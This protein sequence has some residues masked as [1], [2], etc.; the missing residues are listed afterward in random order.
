MKLF[1]F[2]MRDGYFCVK[3]DTIIEKIYV[4]LYVLELKLVKLLLDVK[5]AL[6]I[7]FLGI[8]EFNYF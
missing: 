2:R 1:E 5:I 6:F 4:Y 3:I 7:L 8:P